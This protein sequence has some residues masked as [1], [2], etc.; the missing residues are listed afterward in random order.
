[1]SYEV[2]INKAWEDLAKVS[3]NDNL[4]LKFFNDEYALDVKAKKILSLSCNVKAKDFTSILLLH[5]LIKKLGGLPKVTGN[6][7]TFR[8]ISGVE[9]YGPAFKE[10]AIDPIIRKLKGLRQD[11]SMLLEAL[12]GVPVLVK[13]FKQDDEFNADANIYFDSSIKDIFCTEDIVVLSGMVAGRLKE[14]LEEA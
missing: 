14:F 4:T 1:M 5:Y 3:L 9:G 11:K 7:L 6:W 12:E 10:R 13:F 2:A 8:E